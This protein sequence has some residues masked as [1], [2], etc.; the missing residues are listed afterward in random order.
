MRKFRITIIVCLL[1]ALAVPFADILAVSYTSP[2]YT[3]YIYIIGHGSWLHYAVNVW[4]LLVLHNLFNW[5]RVLFSYALAV[6]I[7]YVLL[8]ELPMIGASVIT[9]FFIGFAAPYFWFKNRTAVLMTTCLLALTCILPGFAGLQHVV[10]FF[11]GLSFFF[12]ERY[13]KSIKQYLR[14]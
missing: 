5:Y 3:H 6:A 12:V 8:P 7:S 10:V 14:E 1:M 4:T 13:V 9:C 2:T 11:S